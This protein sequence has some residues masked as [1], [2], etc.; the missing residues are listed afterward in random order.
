MKFDDDDAVEIAIES[1]EVAKFEKKHPD[2]VWTVEMMSKKESYNW[3]SSHSKEKIVDSV[4]KV[5]KNLWKVELEAL[6]EEKLILIID[7]EKRKIMDYSI[8]KIETIPEQFV[9]DENDIDF[10]ENYEDEQFDINEIDEF[11]E[12]NAIEIAM[13]SERV[14]EFEKKYPGCSWN[15]EFRNNLW[16]IDIESYGNEKLILTVDPEKQSIVKI[17][18][19]ELRIDE[20]EEEEIDA[21]EEEII[22]ETEESIHEEF[23]DDQA[24]EIVENS[25][26]CKE[27]EKLYPNCIWNVT[28]LEKPDK[29]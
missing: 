25:E 16:I 15:I 13:Q 4:L 14:L 22:D 11:S 23:T 21:I 17:E 6:D 2:C 8:E 12:D 24:V 18:Q 7:P 29:K 10:E 26:E 19:Q 5:K 9:D 20:D 3:I 27:F 28:T 1:N